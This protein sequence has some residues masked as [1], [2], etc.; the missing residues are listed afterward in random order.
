HSPLHYSNCT[1]T[2]KA[3][4]IGINYIG[5]KRELKG[6]VNDA[7]KIREF[8]IKH[9][10]Y[11]PEDIVL[12]M[13]E[14][15]HPRRVPTKKNMLDGMKWLVKGAQPHDSL[16]FHYSGHGGQ[17]PD[18]D[19]DEVDGMDDVIYPVDFQKAG[20]ILDDEMH[21]IMVKSLPAQCRLTA[22][23]DSCHSGTVL[24]LPYIYHHDGRLKGSQV[25]PEW[26]E[27][28]S[29]PADVISFTGCR[30]DQTSA[31]TTQGGDAVGAM[32][33]AFRE[34]LSENKDQSYQDLLNSVRGLLKDN[35]K[36]T[37]QL[38]SSHRI[39]R[40]L[41]YHIPRPSSFQH[42]CGKADRTLCIQHTTLRF[43][44]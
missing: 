15:T 12:L 29:S 17:V 20:I 26:R 33:W 14:T 38:S 8:L 2:K 9:W 30:D 27:Y 25:T 4:L 35:Y 44:M 5:Q 24:D 41:R 43:I 13:D 19:G 36:Q 6:C 18:K 42:P 11:K 32:S 3:L 34:S 28:K 10:G 7:R 39:V 1:G 31:D 23:Y 21:K 37:P 16:F 40:S 22:I